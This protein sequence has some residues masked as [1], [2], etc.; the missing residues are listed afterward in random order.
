MSLLKLP[1]VGEGERTGSREVFSVVLAEFD[2]YCR[3]C[4]CF[5][6]C[7]DPCYRLMLCNRIFE[8]PTLKTLGRMG[9]SFG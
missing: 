6:S 1:S 2:E 5:T 3:P 7:T 4:S 8:L 9:T